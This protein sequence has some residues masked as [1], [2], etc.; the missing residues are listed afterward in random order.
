MIVQDMCCSYCTCADLHLLHRHGYLSELPE[1]EYLPLFWTEE[2]R[3]LL[4][5]TDIADRAD[6]DLELTQEDFETNVLPLV[7]QYPDRMPLPAFNLQTFRIAASWVASRAFGVD[8]Y[9]G[10]KTRAAPVLATLATGKSYAG[11]PCSPSL[12]LHA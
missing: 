5:G 3:I 6:E 12:L 8:S 1:R 4:Q 2:E 10:A 11:W 7:H 9:H